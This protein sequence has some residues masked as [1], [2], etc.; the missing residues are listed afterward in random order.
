[1][2][3]LPVRCSTVRGETPPLCCILLVRSHVLAAAPQEEPPL[4]PGHWTP[5]P[6]CHLSIEKGC[7]LEFCL[8]GSD[9]RSGV[10]SLLYTLPP[11]P[12]CSHCAPGFLAWVELEGD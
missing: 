6:A 5:G 10:L 7:L 1:M 11:W 4:R 2:P 12:F 9:M 3:A 8:P